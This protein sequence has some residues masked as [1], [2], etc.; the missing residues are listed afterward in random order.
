MEQIINV[1]IPKA[2]R[3]KRGEKSKVLFLSMVTGSRHGHVNKITY[4]ITLEESSTLAPG[5]QYIHSFDEYS[6][7]Y[8]LP[9][10][11]SIVTLGSVLALRKSA[12][13]QRRKTIK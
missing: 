11:M 10:V 6:S 8:S 4:P 2:E 7:S 5:G 13:Q 9:G 12:I 1:Y 3:K